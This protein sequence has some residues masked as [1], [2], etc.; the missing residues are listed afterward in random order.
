MH[1]HSGVFAAA[2]RILMDWL[3]TQEISSC[4]VGGLL[5]TVFYL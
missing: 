2:P 5:F 4:K 3:N 1:V